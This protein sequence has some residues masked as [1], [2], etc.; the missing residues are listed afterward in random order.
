MDIKDAHIL[1][2]EKK[3]ILQNESVA[4]T[5]KNQDINP[6]SQNN[7]TCQCKKTSKCVNLADKMGFH[8]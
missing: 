1:K 3:L 2:E 6:I 4:Y 5:Q 8:H 7:G